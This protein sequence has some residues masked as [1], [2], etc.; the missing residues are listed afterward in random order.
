M[1]A[2]VVSFSADGECNSY[3]SDI[4]F[5]SDK[6]H[7]VP[8]QVGISSPPGLLS[9]LRSRRH[10]DG[11][12]KTRDQSRSSSLVAWTLA[13]AHYEERPVCVPLP[14]RHPSPRLGPQGK[15]QFRVATLAGANRFILHST[16]RGSPKRLMASSG[17]RHASSVIEMDA[18][19][20]VLMVSER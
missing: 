2:L 6:K 4:N 13:G 17:G 20:S 5:R 7:V 16:A 15:H 12:R 10:P 19:S 9:T 11:R 3:R 1:F 14:H 18:L 8:S